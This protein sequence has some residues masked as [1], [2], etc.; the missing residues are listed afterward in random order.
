M[1]KITEKHNRQSQDIDS[2][3]TIDILKIINKE[4]SL[5]HEHIKTIL[6]DINNV[7]E[8][9]VHC[10]KNNGNLI[11]IG[12]GTSGR[13]GILDAVECPPT[14]STSPSLVQGFIAGGYDALFKSVENAEDSIV[15]AKNLINKTISKNDFVLGI[16]ASG[17][18]SFV[19]AGLKEAK[20]IKA[21][22]GLLTC[23]DVKLD[24][25]VD[26]IISAIVGPEIIT[27]STRMKAGTATKMILN[28]ISTTSMIKL[29]K[30]YGN[31]MVDLKISNK[32]LLDRGIRIIIEITSID[33]DRASKLL[34]KAE[35]NVKAAIVMEIKNKTLKESLDLLAKNNGKI[36]NIIG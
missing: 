19:T 14:F 11:Y 8:S 10:L 27:G 17:G 23:N 30:T 16:S 29:N 34:T 26:H 7:I 33:Y 36:R 6:P 31:I 24:F 15:Q 20:K 35:N 4:D 5:I 18:A 21:K 32:K 2:L 3:S 22:T 1:N 13:L 28:M 9:I 25:F 12:C